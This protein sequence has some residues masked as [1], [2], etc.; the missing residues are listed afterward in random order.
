MGWFVSQALVSSFRQINWDE[1]QIARWPIALAAVGLVVQRVLGALTYALLLQSLGQ[2]VRWWRCLAIIWAASLGRY[3]P[4]K[5][6]AA[7][8]AAALLRGEG[9]AWSTSA[10][11]LTLMPMLSAGLMTII[12]A[13]LLLSPSLEQVAPSFLLIGVM[14]GG[15]VGVTLLTPLLSVAVGLVGASLGKHRPGWSC[16]R[17][18]ALWPYAAAVGVMAVNAAVQGLAVWL[19]LRSLGTVG[20]EWLAYATGAAALVNVAGF[21]AFFAPAGLGVQDGLYLVL[22]GGALG[23]QAALVAVLM[24]LL[25]TVVDAGSGLAGLALLRAGKQGGE[26]A[27]GTEVWGEVEGV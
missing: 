6:A 12:A 1:V 2:R 16:P 3:V 17:V 24:R 4:G 23:P 8:S 9:V 7:T 13:P 5:V 10:V 21:L 14:V 27:V 11:V 25:R 19:V 22:F 26:D 18:V 15:A 20:G